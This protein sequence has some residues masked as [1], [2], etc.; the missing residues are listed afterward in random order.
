[1]ICLVVG[2][3]CLVRLRILFFLEVEGNSYEQNLALKYLYKGI[4]ISLVR[5]RH[6]EALS[7]TKSTGC[8]MIERRRHFQNLY[9]ASSMMYIQKTQYS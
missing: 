9:I 4:C 6:H 1:M 5:S 7:P 3:G 2:L 8:E